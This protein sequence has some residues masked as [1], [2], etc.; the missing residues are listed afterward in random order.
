MPIMSALPLLTKLLY[1]NIVWMGWTLQCYPSSNDDFA[2]TIKEKKFIRII[3]GK[4]FW[5]ILTHCLLALNYLGLNVF[6]QT[7]DLYKFQSKNFFSFPNLTCRLRTAIGILKICK[8]YWAPC[9]EV[10]TL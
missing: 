4:I 2:T 3:V 9:L 1:C 10:I 7:L 5:L 6:I 8:F